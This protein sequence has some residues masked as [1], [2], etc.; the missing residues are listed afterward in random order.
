MTPTYQKPCAAWAE[1]LAASPQD[2]TWAERAALDQHVASCPACAATRSA[3]QQ[4]DSELTAMPL[5]EPRRVYAEQL[6]ERNDLFS[7]PVLAGSTKST[8]SQQ[9][10]R[11]SE[12]RTRASKNIQEKPFA[13]RRVRIQHMAA[14][15]AAVLVVCALTGSAA[16]LF[17]RHNSPQ[18]GAFSHAGPLTVYAA[19]TN[20][21]VYA[22]RPDSGAI[23]W[24]RQLNLGG[25]TVIGGPT[26]AHGAVYVGAMNGSLYA[27]RTS[28]GT[29]LWQRPLPDQPSPARY[30][31]AR[32]A[33]R[34]K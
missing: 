5:I 19:L 23:R 17:S 4:M 7:S 16:L 22:L 12:K 8:P 31:S 11:P 3:Y 32:R 30:R 28:D 27:L 34:K 26:I 9:V 29:L 13:L 15:L 20:G 25:Q 24:Q 6:P 21:T 33:G 1:Q 18:I 10:E 14:T 2:L